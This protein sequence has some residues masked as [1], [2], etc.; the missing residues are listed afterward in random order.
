MIDFAGVIKAQIPEGTVKKI[1]IGGQQAWNDDR[2][3]IDWKWNGSLPSSSEWTYPVGSGTVTNAASQKAILLSSEGYDEKAGIYPKAGTFTPSN[4][5]I[6]EAEIKVTRA[7]HRERGVHIGVSNAAGV[8]G[9][10]AYIYEDPEADIY[11]IVARNGGFKN[12]TGDQW[13][14]VRLELDTVNKS[15]RVYI[16]DVLVSSLGN[17]SLEANEISAPY[18]NTTVA[19]CYVRAMRY[20]VIK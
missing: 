10:L 16:D 17:G 19:D 9:L 6:F 2:W 11:V 3:E 18:L 20:K 7:F 15:N 1:E 12:T 14:T 4:R 13:H 5:C 8:S